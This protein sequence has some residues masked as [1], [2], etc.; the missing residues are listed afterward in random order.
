MTHAARMLIAMMHLMDLT[1]HQ[2]T[3]NAPVDGTIVMIIPLVSDVSRNEIYLN[4][5]HY[6]GFNLIIL[7]YTDEGCQ[8]RNRAVCRLDSI[9]HI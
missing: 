5:L 1:V 9:E 2:A 3:V 7:S 8:A 4:V 6:L